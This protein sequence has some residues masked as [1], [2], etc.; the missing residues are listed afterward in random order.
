MSWKAEYVILI[1]LS[2]ITDYIAGLQIYKAKKQSRKKLFLGLSLLINLGLLF[3]FKYFNF[4]SQATADFLKLFSI[5]FSPMTLK[6]LLPVG[7]SFYTFQT[8]SYTIDIYRGK[9][10]PEKHLGVFAVYVSFFPQLVAGPIE[11]AKNLLPQFFKKHPFEYKRVTTGL[12]I[13][14]WGFFL[15]LVVADRAAIVVNQVYNNVFDYTGASLILATLLFTAQ[16]Y[17]DFAGY[18]FIAIG[19]A[20]VLGFRLMENFRRP[21]FSKSV[22][23]FWRRWHISLSSWFQ[24]YVFIPLYRCVAKIKLLKNKEPKVKHRLSFFISMLIGLTLLGLWHGAAWRF[25]LFGIY[26]AILVIIYYSIQKHWHKLNKYIQIGLTFCAI[27]FGLSVFRANNLSESVYIITNMFSNLWTS[28]SG[29]ITGTVTLNKI[30]LYILFPAVIFMEGTHLA[31]EKNK[32]IL[33]FLKV[34]PIWLRWGAYF[35][36]IL[37]ILIFGVFNKTPFIYFQ[38]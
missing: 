6:V 29:L 30:S 4:F 1:M 19:A 24:D 2:T 8:L 35:F 5:P 28:S 27:A 17:G 38:F 18:S 23:E 33:S 10:K 15:K 37:T 36:V 12:K 20:K 16:V 25:V 34:K 32:N 22:A 21:Y 14:L 13:M 9:I 31:Q 26:N 11:R 7:I 3:M